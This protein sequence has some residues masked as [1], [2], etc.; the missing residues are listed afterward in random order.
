MVFKA[1]LGALGGRRLGPVGSG[2]SVGSESDRNG[3][4]SEC[5]GF[6]EDVVLQ[7]CG[8]WGE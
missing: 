6:R 4:W 7:R 2:T 1:A 3:A 5:D 8:R